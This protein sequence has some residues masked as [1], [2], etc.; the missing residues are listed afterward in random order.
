[1]LAIMVVIFS[2][3]VLKLFYV[4][5][6]SYDDYKEMATNRS[7]KQ[8][9]EAA[10]RGMILDKNGEVLAKSEQSYA[11]V[12]METSEN[13]KDIFTTLENLFKVLDETGETIRDDFS[14]KID[15]YRFE[16]SS[17]D[18]DVKRNMEIRFKRDRGFHEEIKRKLFKD[19]EE[20]TEE[21]ESQINDELLKITPEE[22]FDKLV[23]DYELYKLIGLEKKDVTD[24]KTNKSIM[25]GTEIKE[26]LLEKYSLEE[27]RKY[28]LVRD[29]IK[30]QMFTGYKPVI[31]ASNV[32]KD[33]AFIF[34][35][36]LNEMPGIDVSIQPTRVYPYNNLASSV[37]GYIGSINSSQKDKYEER[38][39]DVSVDSI[40]KSGIES[41][42]EDR[43]KGAKGGTVVK[44]NKDGRKTEELFKLDP[45]PG[46]NVQLTI[47]KDVQ[48]AAERAL[49]DTMKELQ[50]GGGDL[51]T[52]NAT[53]GAVIAQDIKTGKIIAMASN[54]SFDPN[55]FAVPG[56][57]NDD[58]IKE[59]FSPDLEK[60]GNDYI[61]K[62]G[63]NKTVDD[64]FPIDEDMKQKGV[65]VRKD[66]YDIYP[67]PFFN[68]ATQ[69]IVPPGSTY[70][71]VT[72]VAGLETGVINV[73]DTI[74]DTNRYNIYDD[75]KDFKG[76]NDGGVAHGP[77]NIVNALAKSS[78]FFFFET[79]YR[80]GKQY[81]LD[82]LAEYSWKFGLG[83]NPADGQHSTTGI[84][85]EEATNGQVFNFESNKEAVSRLI[86]FDVVDKFN[87]GSF[88]RRNFTPIDIGKKDSDSEE[89]ANAKQVIKD[90]VSNTITIEKAPKVE[91]LSKELKTKL[92]LYIN[93]LSEGEKEAYL[94]QTDAMAYDLAAYIIF[95]IRANTF[96][97]Y[98]V[99]NAAVGQGVNQFNLLQLSNYISTV[100][101]GGTRYRTHLVDK[102]TDAEGNII[103][104]IQPEVLE[105]LDVKPENLNIV[106]EGFEKVDSS[107]GTARATFGEGFPINTAGKTGSAT[108][109]EDG[110]QE[111]VGRTSYSVYVGYAPADNPE[112]AVSV[113]IYD[114]G[115]GGS[116]APVAKAIYERYFKER[117]DAI[118][119]KPQYDYKLE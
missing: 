10:P 94:K 63:L 12:Y 23:K 34:L 28:M 99:L 27:I 1:M 41:A 115:H 117:L 16:F 98:N 47:D 48:Y 25:S 70:K 102:I 90:S 45:Y 2:L 97:I 5:V 24:S 74:N 42:F 7:T 110:V 55:L 75:I 17:T 103:E 18:P 58:Q 78:N 83:Y 35:Q 107:D 8:I 21:Q 9:A 6:V 19:V 109:R 88:G 15:P 43:L 49:D 69:G 66:T 3:L 52:K 82:K 112:I 29:T 51:N 11:V 119:Y 22:C 30:M 46:Q 32:K 31:L 50:R 72:A 118:G 59:Y 67:K 76:K 114:G 101:N 89:I 93:L 4:Q 20:L 54:P 68:Y 85:I 14:L 44:V 104:E 37:I 91:D 105:K 33:S 71:G 116:A 56:R 106:K 86:L 96:G 113:I 65:T 13:K 100:A 95:D 73:N 92:D 57:L 38:G 84:E 79:G 108:F 26:K 111:E 60:F 39:Y 81:G 61:K 36:K 87:A 62:M 64:L 77:I 40:G 53:R 80:M